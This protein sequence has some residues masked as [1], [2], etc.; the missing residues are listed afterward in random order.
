MRY[1]IAAELAWSSTSAEQPVLGSKELL[2]KLPEER[3]DVVVLRKVKMHGTK[4][5]SKR[6][7]GSCDDGWGEAP[8]RRDIRWR[9]RW[10]GTTQKNT[11]KVLTL[12]A[13]PRKLRR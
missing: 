6:A 12:E 10:W 7:L 2:P 4:T 9:L 13:C 3:L 11:K 8:K 5:P 1:R